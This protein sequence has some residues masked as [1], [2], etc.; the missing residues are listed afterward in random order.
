METLPERPAW[1]KTR[2]FEQLA[3][4]AKDEETRMIRSVRAVLSVTAFIGT[5]VLVACGDDDTPPA[6]YPTVDSFCDGK[7]AAE[8]EVVSPSC[9]ITVDVCKARRAQTCRSGASSAVGRNYI[10]GRAD[11]CIAKT[12]AVY[13]DRQIDPKK[14]EAFQLACEKVFAGTKKKSEPCTNLYECDGSLVCDVEKGFCADKVEKKQNDGCNNAGDICAT[15]LFC[16]D[17][18]G[19]K[20]CSPKKKVDEPCSPTIPCVEEARCVSTICKPRV[21]PGEPCNA[22]LDC[23]TNFCDTTNPNSRVCGAKLYASETGSC[24]DFGGT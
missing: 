18:G 13:A 1:E 4:V 3:K 16:E 15:G 2:S 14:E 17:R 24:K 6:K 8:C 10:P 7:A 22:N 11:D 20:F 23:L 19:Q 9:R 21:G 5:V 12:K